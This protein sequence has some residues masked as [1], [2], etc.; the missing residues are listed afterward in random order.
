[1]LFA[2]IVI[3]GLAGC[4]QDIVAR[5]GISPSDQECLR[6]AMDRMSDAEAGGFDDDTQEQVL[7]TTYSECLAWHEKESALSA[8]VSAP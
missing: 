8:P 2:S 6:V 5:A 3:C 4:E 1:M 7:K